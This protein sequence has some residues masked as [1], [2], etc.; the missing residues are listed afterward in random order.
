MELGPPAH[1]AEV[2]L[3]RVGREAILYDR[4]NGRAHVINAS[5]A[6][7]WDLCDGRATLD[8]ITGA[9]AAAYNLP[10]ASVRD[11]VV[12]IITSFRELRVL[13]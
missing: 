11:D 7:V 4:R 5:A 3:Q 1:R 2:T 6:R 12:Q 9:L 8:D 13:D 10:P